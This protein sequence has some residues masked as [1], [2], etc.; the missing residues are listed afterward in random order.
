MRKALLTTQIISFVAI[1]KR[2]LTR[3]APISNKVGMLFQYLFFVPSFNLHYWTISDFLGLIGLISFWTSI[4]LLYFSNFNWKSLMQINFL[5]FFVCIIFT[6][7]S[8]FFFGRFCPLSWIITYLI[9]F[10]ILNEYK[11]DNLFFLKSEH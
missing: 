6:F 8:L 3:P 4:I 9:P 7:I 10:F 5:A 2:L 1:I 11:V